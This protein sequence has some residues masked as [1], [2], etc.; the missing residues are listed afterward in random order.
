MKKRMLSLA[1]LGIMIL[2][3]FGVVSAT[4]KTVFGL[5]DFESLTPIAWGDEGYSTE[6]DTATFTSNLSALGISVGGKS[7]DTRSYNI[8]DSGDEERGNYLELKKVASNGMPNITIPITYKQNNDI[9][10]Y[11]YDFYRTDF[12]AGV[13]YNSI[14]ATG[15][16]NEGVEKNLVNAYFNKTATTFDNAVGATPSITA[17]V[18][19]HAKVTI[20]LSGNAWTVAFKNLET[21]EEKSGKGNFGNNYGIDN[22]TKIYFCVTSLSAPTGSYY[23]DNIEAYT[24]DK[25]V[26][27][28]TSLASTTGVPVDTREIKVTMSADIDESSLDGITVAPEIGFAATAS[29]KDITITFG[30]NLAY[31]TEYT[32]SLAGVA[33]VGGLS[34]DN[35]V[36]VT[37][38]T[39]NAPDIQLMNVSY[40]GGI[41]AEYQPASTLADNSFV[42]AKLTLKNNTAEAKDALVVLVTYK[43]NGMLA[44]CHYVNK[45]FAAN[46]E[47]SITNGLLLSGMAGGKVKV[48]VW[49]GPGSLR[50]WQ[51]NI[52][53]QAVASN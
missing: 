51:I 5:E 49:D 28:S 9:F 32:I 38:T 18:W 25:P 7:N 36:K 42:S 50:P 1:L 47:V 6:E 31:K 19:H 15:K 30:T 22:I 16:N 10:V 46:E 53:E 17:N 34:A 11:E 8:V 21:G 12:A 13:M 14:Q 37:F 20:D 41:G 33:A 52:G 26:V 44:D 45:T 43:A 27:S 2:S 3:S 39:E 35:A 24:I 48:F 40:Y 4:G 29:G 23:L